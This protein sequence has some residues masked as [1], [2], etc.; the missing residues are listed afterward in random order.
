MTDFWT[1]KHTELSKSLIN[2]N[3]WLRSINGGEIHFFPVLL[4]HNC[5]IKL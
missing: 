5:Q 4:G 2:K 3:G 1:L